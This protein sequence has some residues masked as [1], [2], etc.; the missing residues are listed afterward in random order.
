MGLPPLSEGMR[1]R[2][3]E[4]GREWAKKGGG[5]LVVEADEADG[6]RE[7]RD[8][9]HI[10]GFLTSFRTPNLY[11]HRVGNREGAGTNPADSKSREGYR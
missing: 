2:F 4:G 11:Q 10:K 1:E 5:D 3:S 8:D 6:G 7:R 9:Q